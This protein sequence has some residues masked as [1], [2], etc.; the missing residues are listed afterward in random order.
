MTDGINKI[1]DL[2]DLITRLKQAIQRLDAKC[3]LLNDAKLKAADRAKMASI[4]DKIARVQEV[5]HADERLSLSVGDNNMEEDDHDLHE[6]EHIE[7]VRKHQTLKTS[8]VTR[9]NSVLYMIESALSLWEEMN[10]A[11]KVNGDRELCMSDDDKIILM[12]L[13]TFLKP[14]G[15]LTDL[16]SAEA[17]H[18]SLIPLVAREV[19]DAAKALD[20]EAESI[21]LLKHT[22]LANADA[23]LCVSETAKVV[24]LL[25]P[26]VKRII[27]SEIGASEAKNILKQRAF[28]A[29]QRLHAYRQ[30]KSQAGPVEGE[31]ASSSSAQNRQTM[32]AGPSTAGKNPAREARA[33]SQSEA[34]SKKQQLVEKH[35]P[36]TASDDLELHIESE[37][38][39]YVSL[40]LK[41]S[42]GSDESPL[43]FWKS[44]C[45]N[46]PHLSVLAK[47]YLCLSAS[48]VGVEGMF[49]TAGL[50]LNCKRSLM[51][52]YRANLLSVIH[53]NYS[54]YFP[55][56]HPST[57]KLHKSLDSDSD[58]E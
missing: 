36:S 2:V 55:I 7:R 3:Y 22:V 27:I 17:P 12:E 50:M 47:N 34:T 18:L 37:V 56:G 58:S 29:V 51:A 16:V 26:S 11:L 30:M 45:G 14:F 13:K 9:W 35:A 19:K 31:T 38:S 53:D 4:Q 49:S 32:S 23:R 1:P 5:L 57:S 46:F 54:K 10:D 43:S 15:D 41:Q 42:A 28:K 8:N 21:V 48:S 39:T 25:D 24:A 20:G 33:T 40:D 52:P 6:H 44:Q